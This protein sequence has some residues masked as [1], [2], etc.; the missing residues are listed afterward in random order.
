MS[1]GNTPAISDPLLI[2][3][4]TSMKPINIIADPTIISAVLKWRSSAS[5]ESCS[6]EERDGSGD[7]VNRVA[8][9]WGGLFGSAGCLDLAW[10]ALSRGKPFAGRGGPTRAPSTAA[11]GGRGWGRTPFKKSVS[12]C[13][14]AGT[15]G[16]ATAA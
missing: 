4:R 3:I 2:E 11:G 9:S 13:V 12:H 8:G 14:G 16:A 15:L 6:G 1:I 10:K 7:A 5:S